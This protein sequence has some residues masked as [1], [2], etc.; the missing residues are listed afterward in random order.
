ML[1]LLPLVQHA[2]QAVVA[3][4]SDTQ[5]A[6]LTAKGLT[7]IGKGIAYGVAAGGAGI[8]IGLV[9]ASAIQGIARQPEMSG[10]LQGLM[11]LGFAFIEVLAL[12]GFLLVFVL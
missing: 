12:I 9:F 4:D 7:T 10:P 1:E 3:A 11:Y 5:A 6:V 8:G 2:A